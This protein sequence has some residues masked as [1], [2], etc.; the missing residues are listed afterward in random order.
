[1]VHYILSSRSIEAASDM[2]ETLMQKLLKAN[3]IGSRRMEVISEIDPA[4]YKGNNHIEE[5]IEN[6]VGGV[7]VFDLSEKFGYDSTDYLSASQYLE[8]LVKK[9]RNQCLLS[10]LITWTSRDFP[11]ICCQI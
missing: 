4:F 9:Y 10:L 6:N 5:I 2:V 11:T 3:R 8:M 7:I 1:M